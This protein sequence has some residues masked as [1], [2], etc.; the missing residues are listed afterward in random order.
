[1]EESLVRSE[2]I[3]GGCGVAEASGRT[4]SYGRLVEAFSCMDT[5]HHLDG[6]QFFDHYSY[7]WWC[8]ASWFFK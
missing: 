3:P 6:G 2:V 7:I 4:R 5:C 8:L 1:M